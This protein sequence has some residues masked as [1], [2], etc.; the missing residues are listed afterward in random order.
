MDSLLYEYLGRGIKSQI[1]QKV[2]KS[3]LFAN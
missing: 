3:A 1:F 2:R